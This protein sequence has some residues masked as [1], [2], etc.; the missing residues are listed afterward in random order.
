MENGRSSWANLLCGEPAGLGWAWRL[1]ELNCPKAEPYGFTLYTAA[2]DGR[3]PREP[4]SA[5]ICDFVLIQ[6]LLGSAHAGEW[7]AELHSA[8]GELASLPKAISQL[9]KEP[10][11]KGLQ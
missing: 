3:A 7:R 6:C 5:L 4:S 8:G 10:F 9:Q 11:G 1:C 2:G